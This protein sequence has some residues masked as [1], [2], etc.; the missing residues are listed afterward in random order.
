MKSEVFPRLEKSLTQNKAAQNCG[1]GAG[2]HSVCTMEERKKERIGT[3]M[4]EKKKE[5]EYVLDQK[6]PGVKFTH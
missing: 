5:F 2:F 3:L 6:F 4:E 1:F